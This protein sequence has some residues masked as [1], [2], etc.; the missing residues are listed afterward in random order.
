MNRRRFNVPS[1]VLIMCTLAHI[2]V[3]SPAS[4]EV[5]SA[6]QQFAV[7]GR[8][9]QRRA[10]PFSLSV[11]ARSV[12]VTPTLPTATT[13][14]GF[15]TDQQ[16]SAGLDTF[17]LVTLVGHFD[18]DAKQDLIS[19]VEDADSQCW[20]SVLLGDRTGNL[21]AP[22]LTSITFSP[23]DLI[24]V[25]D[26]NGDGL[27]DVV[28]V[29]ANLVDVFISN[30]AGGFSGPFGHVTTIANPVAATLIDVNGDS[31]LDIMVADGSNSTVATLA[32]SGDGNFAAQTTSNYSGTITYG[33]FADLN[34]DGHPDLV[35]SNQVFLGTAGDFQAPI[36][37]TSGASTCTYA[38]GPAYGSVVIADVNGDGKPD[39]ITPDCSNQTITAYLND[40]SSSFSVH[41]ST[42]AGYLPSALTVADVNKDNKL[43]VIV[44]DFFSMDIVVMLG[45]N[46]GTFAPGTMGYPA[47]GELW[48]APAIADFNSDTYPDIVIPSGI[49]AQWENVVYL[50]GLG[51][52]TFVAPHDY[53]FMGGGQGT[54]ANASG[55]AAADLNGDGLPDFAVGSLSNNPEVGVTVFLS[56][57]TNPNQS[58][59]PGLNYGSGGNLQFV[60]LADMDGDGKKELVASNTL[61][62]SLVAGSIEIFRG[63]SD[64]T[65]EAVPTTISVTSGRG[66]GQLVIG[67]FDANQ[68]P[69]IAV[70]DTGVISS[71]DQSFTGNV[72]IVLNNS[73]PGSFSFASPVSYGLSG[74]GGY[75]TASD[76]GNGHTDLVISQAGG[77]GV[78]STLL[79]NGTGIFATPSD[80]NL[81]GFYPAGLAIAKLNPSPAAHPDL[82]VALD[83]YNTNM[84]IVVASGNGDGTFN[85]GVIYPATALTTGTIA[86]IPTDVKVADLDGDGNLDVVFTNAGNGTVGVLYGTG[87]WGSGQSPFYRP[88]EFSANGYPLTLLLADA[89]GDGALDAIVS[90]NGYSGVTTLLNTGA[91][92]ISMSQGP[93]ALIQ[94]NGKHTARA[95]DAPGLLTF[96]ATVSP[97]PLTD[98][99]DLF[100]I[101]APG[102]TVTFMDGNT[103]LGSGEVSGG[104][105]T[106][107]PTIV[108]AGTHVI[109]AVYSGDSNYI[110]QTKA[111]FI[112]NIDAPTAGYLLTS[113]SS[114]A[115]LHPGQSASFVV[116]AT[117]D[118]SYN[119]TVDFSCG[120]LL[121]VICIFSPTTV[122]LS[123][124]TP[125]STNLVITV[126][127]SFVASNTPTPIS[128]AGRLATLSLALLG[129]V[130]VGFRRRGSYEPWRWA[131]A[132]PTLAMLLA[133]VG[134]GNSGT[135]S[136]PV[137]RKSTGVKVVATS[138]R[139]GAT[140]RLNLT[141]NIEP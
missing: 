132:I 102:G 56:D 66:L 61:P 7:R 124:A 55:I 113:D 44:A 52:G 104:T 29:D 60:A 8:T 137:P 16:F 45:N 138:H 139:T 1:I 107:Q 131:I 35:S 18:N 120:T 119:G 21:S 72:W 5:K 63:K 114:S 82:I 128:G 12:D 67:H 118:G 6:L 97:L 75:I 46:D 54:N 94:R 57:I 77:S 95:H 53:F 129:C 58:L 27:T 59:R 43:D 103:E 73:T 50:P 115:T 93:V 64:G 125:V 141:L 69:D 136:L 98:L 99:T 68:R 25:G 74:A 11:T 39:V 130:A 121:G 135:S 9:R 116:T 89:N 49:P 70:L 140:Q 2:S 122:S 38:F 79:G 37:L 32:G 48:T 88:V 31:S 36:T 84:G 26:V 47:G 105:A 23:T 24:A 96:T 33:V 42:W 85:P 92:E 91:N 76:L 10:L 80:F 28:L 17:P 22:V 90:G 101:D 109:T 134:C 126:A 112:E 51:D 111:T 15:M 19:I 106:I 108:T 3:A 41:K 14:I 4:H 30:G 86:P 71:V 40:I 133:T 83:D 100:P 110:G 13:Q 127:P 117:P 34:A 62:G 87:Q 78:I 20:L 65:F 81:D 123:G